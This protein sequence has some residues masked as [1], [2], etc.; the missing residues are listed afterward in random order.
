MCRSKPLS[1]KAS[2]HDEVVPKCTIMVHGV[3]FKFI[4]GVKQ[5]YIVTNDVGEGVNYTKK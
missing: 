2:Q 3:G 1:G 5:Y 4:V